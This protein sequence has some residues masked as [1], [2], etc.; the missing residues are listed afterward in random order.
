MSREDKLGRQSDRLALILTGHGKVHDF[1]TL[2]EFE[3]LLIQQ[4]MGRDHRKL[5]EA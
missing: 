2:G 1:T 5:E 4:H 3:V